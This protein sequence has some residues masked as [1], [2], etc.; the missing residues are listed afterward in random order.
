M[1]KIFQLPQTPSV[2][3]SEKTE[4]VFVPFSD[5][6]GDERTRYVKGVPLDRGT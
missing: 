4:T 5:I 6:L 1:V 3:E 2:A